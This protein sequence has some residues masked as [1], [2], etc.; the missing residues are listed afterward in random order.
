MDAYILLG[1]LYFEQRRLE[2]AERQFDRIVA[3]R[4]QSVAPKTVVGIL[5]QLQ[6]RRNEAKAAYREVLAL[7]S[8]AAVAAN[9]LAWMQME[10]GEELNFAL[11]LAQTAK[12]QLPDQHEVNDTLGWIYVK[13]NLPAMAVPQLLRAI[14]TAPNNASY[15]Y[16]LGVA[17]ANL[18]EGAKARASL[19]KALSLDPDFADAAEARQVLAGLKG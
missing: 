4:P 2:E 11:S 18:G 12:A 16:H 8:R 3:R 13:V 10:D 1:Q 7:D 9:N 19:Q 14:D 15:H 6:N 5:Y 17:Y